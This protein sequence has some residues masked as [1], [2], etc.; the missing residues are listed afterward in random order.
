M[1][2]DFDRIH[3][4][5][6]QQNYMLL[7]SGGGGGGSSLLID[8]V[9]YYKLEDTADSAGSHTLTGINTPTVVAAKIDN[10]YQID[11]ANNRY[12]RAADHADFDLGS[13]DLTIAMWIKPTDANVDYAALSKWNF[14]AGDMEY[15]LTINGGGGASTFYARKADDSGNVTVDKNI[16]FTVGTWYWVVV[17]VDHTN[18]IISLDANNG[19]KTTAV[20]STTG[21]AGSQPFE[22]GG[23]NAAA[24]IA[25]NAIVDEVG[26]WRRMLTADEKTSLYNAGTGI[27]YPF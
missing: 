13:V 26:V 11:Q 8:L 21:R 14:G 23:N 22:I 7:N 3:R 20:W 12:L 17:E 16:A 9:A 27:T 10:G 4:V 25:L 5:I 6:E 15:L 24:T 18:D 2:S 1:R 19:G